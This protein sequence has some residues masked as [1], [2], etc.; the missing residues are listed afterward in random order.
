[1]AKVLVIDDE[2]VLSEMIAMLIED[3]GHE[4]IVATNGY[5][6]LTALSRQREVPALIITDVMM[7]RM[8][9]LEFSK[10]IKNDPQLRHVPIIM[11]SAAGK[12][13]DGYAADYFI[14]KPFDLDDLA[15]LVERLVSSA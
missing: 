2:D 5:E 13:I 3:M 7:P 6:A 10:A 1:M 15:N 8:N 11:M 9:G 12:P 4:S 14:H